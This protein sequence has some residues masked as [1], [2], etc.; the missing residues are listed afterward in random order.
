M[1]ERR[2]Q[3]ADTRWS[4]TSEQDSGLWFGILC[5]APKSFLLFHPQQHHRPCCRRRRRRRHPQ[6]ATAKNVSEIPRIRIAVHQASTLVAILGVQLQI[7]HIMKASFF[8][9]L[10]S[11]L[12]LFLFVSETPRFRAN[13]Q[14]FKN[15]T[16]MSSSLALASW[17]PREEE[18]KKR[19]RQEKKERK[20]R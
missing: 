2:Q 19:K 14:L 4:C 17:T 11:F 6:F 20:K 1:L 8:L 16:D 5:H 7:R 18:T 10:F 3:H 9:F 13:I 15:E 12:F